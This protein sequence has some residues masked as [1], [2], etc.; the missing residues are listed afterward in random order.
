MLI[1]N[2]KGLLIQFPLSST[3]RAIW[4]CGVLNEF[5]PYKSTFFSTLITV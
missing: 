3:D 5:C 1:K 2:L 4:A